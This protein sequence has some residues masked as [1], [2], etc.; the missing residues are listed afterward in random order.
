M[1]TIDLRELLS[2]ATPRPWAIYPG[3]NL[4]G[5][6]SGGEY[7]QLIRNNRIHCPSDT[8]LIVALVNNAEALLDEIERLRGALIF[9]RASDAAG[10]DWLDG[11]KA[12][13][14]R[15]VEPCS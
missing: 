13:T 9:I 1:N 2:K 11:L 8:A 6:D 3:N 4:G 10:Q 5:D 14:A 15:I 12:R 7:Q